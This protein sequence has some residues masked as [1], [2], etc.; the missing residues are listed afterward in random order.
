VSVGALAETPRPPLAS[1][2]AV[3][4]ATKQTTLVV[5]GLTIVAAA[6]RFGRLGHQSFWYDEGFTAWLVHHSPGQMF[7]LLPN[8]EL[9]P[10]LYYCIAWVWARIFGYGEVSLRSISALAGVTTVPVAYGA[11]AELISRRAGLIAAAL[12]CCN[13]LLIWYSQEARSYALLVLLAT[14]SLLAFAHARSQPTPRRLGLWALAASLTLATHYFGVLAVVPEGLWLLWIH[15]LD[16]RVLIAVAAV[17]AFGLALLPLAITQRPQA[18]W[19]ARWPLD[20]RL[21]Q[22]APQALLGTGAPARTWLKLAGA[23]AVLLAAGLLALRADVTERRGALVAG[24]LAVAGFLISL[25]LLLAGVDE[26]ITRN[27]I[28]VL[29]PLLVLIAGG[30]GARRAGA[31]GLVGAATLCAVGLVAAIGVAVDS[32][33][34]RPDWRGVAHAIGSRPPT[35]AGRAILIEDYIFL[36]PLAID[37][38]GLRFVKSRGARV[39][40]LDVIAIK[41]PPNSWFCWWGSECNLIRSP[42]D[43]SIHVSGFHRY[44][45][46]LRVGQFSI[47]R[48]RSS[49]PIRLTPRA[50]SRGLTKSALRNDSFTVQ[51]PA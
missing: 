48:L 34:Q 47:L 50:L 1:A 46:V 8:T 37:V 39:N 33:L 11:A 44:G 18:S 24:G 51:P 7:G 20:Q 13:P 25:A 49:V 35:G 14:L 29:I 21:S 19:I 45:P 38:P 10:P 4:S 31:L 36:M 2:R 6:L 27:V 28:V 9:T 40:E 17:G 43:T 32:T 12:V 16:R 3:L 5:V 42:L 22:I 15:R 41:A 23:A 26:L 30:L